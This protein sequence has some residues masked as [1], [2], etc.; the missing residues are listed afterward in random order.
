VDRPDAAASQYPLDGEVAAAHD[1][2]GQVPSLPGA[3]SNTARMYRLMLP[4][5]MLLYI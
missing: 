2:H 4:M 3:V 1:V 5:N